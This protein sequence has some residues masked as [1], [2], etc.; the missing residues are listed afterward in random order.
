MK[1]K[2]LY[3][4]LFATAITLLATADYRELPEADSL[5]HDTIVIPDTKHEITPLYRA[6]YIPDSTMSAIGL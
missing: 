3:S 5:A 4:L 6:Q 1:T 2:I